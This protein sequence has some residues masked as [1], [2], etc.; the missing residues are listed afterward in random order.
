LLIDENKGR[1]L[2]KEK[3][4]KP[5]GLIGVLMKAKRE[6]LLEKIKPEMDLLIQKH[7]FWIDEILYRR[8]LEEIKE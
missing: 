6:G 2:A 7:G 8:V 1:Q 4:I 5:L 3:Q